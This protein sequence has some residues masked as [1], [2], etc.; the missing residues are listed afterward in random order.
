MM[1]KKKQ[2]N[3]AK[4]ADR[5]DKVVEIPVGAYDPIR[6]VIGERIVRPDGNDP[7]YKEVNIDNTTESE[8]PQTN[9]GKE[10]KAGKDSTTDK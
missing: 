6:D 10:K 3:T 7:I 8:S 1:R 2:Q 4:D 5:F 9:N